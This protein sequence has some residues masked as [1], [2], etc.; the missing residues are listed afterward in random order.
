MRVRPEAKETLAQLAE[1]QDRTMSWI[2]EDAIKE[3]AKH[4]LASPPQPNA[5]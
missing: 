3:Y 4:R 5:L 1:Q 2:V